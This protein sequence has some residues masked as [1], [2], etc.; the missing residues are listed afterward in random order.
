MAKGKKV[1]KYLTGIVI[2][3]GERGRD[4]YAPY[5]LKHP[6]EGKI[7][8]VAEPKDARR[9]IFAK[10]YKILAENQFTDYNE[11]LSKPKFADFVIVTTQDQMHVEPAVMAM[12]QG[13]DVLLEKP[14]ALTEADC[15]QLTEVSER[16]GKLLQICHVLR[17]S[18]FFHTVKEIIDR[19]ELGKVVTIQHSE[20]VAHWHYAH[21][22]CRGNWR[23]SATSSPMILAKSCHDMDLLYWFAGAN[24]AKITSLARPTELCEKNKPEGAPLYCIE[25][26]PHSSTCQYDAVPFYT[27]VR[28]MFQDYELSQRHRGMSWIFHQILHHPWVMYIITLGFIRLIWPWHFFPVTVITD[29]TSPAGVE[30]ALRTTT[31]GRCVYQVGDNDQV[32][33]QTVNVLFENGANAS[34]T[35]HSTSYREGREIRIDGTKGS[36]H[37]WFYQFDQYMRVTDHKTGKNRWLDMPLFF[38]AHGGGDQRLMEG[39]LAA[40]RGDAEPLTTARES[41]T[42][43]LMAFAADQAQREGTVVDFSTYLQ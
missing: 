6:E 14:M 36:I 24:P 9:A 32:S 33:S 23:N 20:N 1:S 16:T 34:F 43:H 30:K 15:R 13:Y 3:A 42:S 12:E 27:G 5:L 11:V 18:P 10:K 28:T 21:S 37:G 2:G 22:Y 31:Y 41:L 7:I 25:G 19:G 29:D 26:C 8:A 39:F 17:Y 40:L 38:G 4:A 35:M